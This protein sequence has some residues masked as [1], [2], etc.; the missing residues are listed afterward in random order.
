MNTG[1]MLILLISLHY[2]GQNQF[3]RCFWFHEHGW[4]IKL[5]DVTE[6]SLDALGMKY[7]TEVIYRKVWLISVHAY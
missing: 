4:Q 5:S 3:F 7:E 2:L 6:E 1:C